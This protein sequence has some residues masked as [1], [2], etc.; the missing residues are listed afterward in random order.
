MNR[1]RFAP[2]AGGLLALTLLAGACGNDDDAS[3][4]STFA[5]PGADAEA[6]ARPEVT[7]A[8]GGSN[9]DIPA[10]VPSGFVD[11]RVK[12]IDGEA[13]GGAHLL[14]GRVDDDVT[15][16]EFEAALADE[17]ADL[18]QFVDV[19]GGN[20]TIHT[21]D[22][23]LMTLEL[24]A[25]RYIA[26]NIYFPD[27]EGGPQFADSRF[28]VVDDGNEADAPDE[29]G[30]ITLGPDMLIAVPDDFDGHGVW[31]FEN[32]DPALVHEAAM[33]GLAAGKTSED[34]VNWFHTQD[35]LVPTEGDFGSMG[36]IGPGNEAWIDFDA[37][38][39]EPG[40]YAMVCFLPGA[41]GF[42][43]VFSGMIADVTV[44]ETPS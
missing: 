10:E 7:F 20:G 34:V 37:S 5:E 26:I 6:T 16:E 27:P 40:D 35:G 18:F 8:A 42:P 4:A 13:D 43:H 25:G 24:A 22:E 21:G 36:A 31:R 38:P 15:D 39:V 41:D 44:E 1:G 19:V 28:T 32:R 17:D 33:V 12:S 23:A 2:L 11:I 3:D 9:L 29:R 30:T 14:I